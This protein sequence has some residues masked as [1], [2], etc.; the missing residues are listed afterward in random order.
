VRGKNLAV[1]LLVEPCALDV[2]ELEVGNQARERKRIDRELGDWLVGS[3]IRFVVQDMHRAV[4]YL[5]EIDVTG[6]DSLPIVL[7]GREFDAMRRF[8]RGD[9]GLCQPDR[10]LNRNGHTVVREHEPL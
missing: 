9:V 5:Q 10:D 8:E 7:A 4:S 1:L 6:D 2:E 3:C